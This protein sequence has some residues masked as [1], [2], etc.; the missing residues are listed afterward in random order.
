METPR[1]LIVGGDQSIIFV[2][3]GE[4][5]D[6]GYQ[7][8]WVPSGAEALVKLKRAEFQLVIVH[9]VWLPDID[10]AELI[11]Q[12]TRSAATTQPVHVILCSGGDTRSPQF[13]K[14]YHDA[15]AAE[16]FQNPYNLEDLLT[17]IHD[18]LTVT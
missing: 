3:Q 9:S 11:S 14:K 1:I 5:E 12:I 10:A 8:F 16:I 4:L 15:G 2:L 13:A 17:A 6:A 18:F 7:V